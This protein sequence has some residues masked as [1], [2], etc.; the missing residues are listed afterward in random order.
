MAKIKITCDST[1]DLTD[2]IYRKLD[3]EVVPLG[4]ILGDELKRDGV[5][6]SE[7]ELFAYTERT[8]TLPKTS[9]ISVG[10]YAEVFRKFVSQG[11]SVIHVSLSSELSACYSNA[12]MAAEEVGSVWA[13]DSLNLS[14]G[15][16]HLVMTAAELAEQGYEAAEIAERLNVLRERLDVSFVL[17]T[18]EYLHK[19]GRCS[20]VALL[21]ANLMK[22]RP[23][24]RVIGGGMQVGSKLRGNM[25]ATVMKYIRVRLEGRDD[26]DTRRIFVTHTEMP[27]EIVDEAMDLVRQLHPF[28]EVIETMASSTISSHCGPACLGVLFY[29]KGE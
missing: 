17:Q 18:L 24:I 19:G 28:D 1:C 23:E 21:G 22:I 15:S 29:K 4:V 13:V 9:A 20:G 12:R 14:S 27:R 3:V 16:G 10:E 2:E 7:K 6:V 5:N 8:G 25:R 26:I 11:Y